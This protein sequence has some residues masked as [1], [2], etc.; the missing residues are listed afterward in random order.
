MF[1]ERLQKSTEYME[2][3]NLSKAALKKWKILRIIELWMQKASKNIMEYMLGTG[4]KTIWRVM[5]AVA[6]QLVPSYYKNVEKI[7]GKGEIVEIDESKFG[8]RKYNR[9][10]CVDGV[11][12]LGAV[13]KSNRKRIILT[14]VDNRTK[15]TLT[16][17]LKNSINEDSVVYTDGWKGYNDLSDHIKNSGTCTAIVNKKN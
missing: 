1:M 12:V 3:N 11:W 5:K 15:E 16:E 6:S 8:K 9:G 10:H 17:K 13:E 14:I 7:G 2:G 4:R